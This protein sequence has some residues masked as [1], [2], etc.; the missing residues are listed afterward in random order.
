LNS[1]KSDSGPSVNSVSDDEED[2]I[3]GNSFEIMNS[4]ISDRM[5]LSQKKLFKGVEPPVRKISACE[6][7]ELSNNLVGRV[8]RKQS[9]FIKLDSFGRASLDSADMQLKR[10]SSKM[11]RRDTKVDIKAFNSKFTE[12]QLKERAKIKQRLLK[13]RWQ[14]AA[15]DDL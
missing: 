3:I 14:N 12:E 4:L 13:S 11:K 9:A 1:I 10:S 8:K 6:V 5:L 15:D 2:D 7:T